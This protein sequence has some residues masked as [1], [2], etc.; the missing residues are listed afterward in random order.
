MLAFRE[1]ILSRETPDEKCQKQS[2]IVFFSMLPALSIN[3]ISQYFYEPKM[4]LAQQTEHSK[5]KPF[6]S[7]DGAN[8]LNDPREL[9][10]P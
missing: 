3:I 10:T 1:S 9:C 4:I 2:Y 7:Q 8:H 5:L 6:K